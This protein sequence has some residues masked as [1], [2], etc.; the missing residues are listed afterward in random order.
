MDDRKRPA[1]PLNVLLAAR[2]VNRLGAFTL[3]FLAVLLTTELDASVGTAGLVLTVF[4]LATIPSRL[5]G[6][7][8]SDRIGPRRTIVLGLIGCAAGQLWLAVAHSIGSAFAA[9]CLLGLAFEIYE[10]PSQALVAELV[11]PEE[12][13]RAYGRFGAALAVA[14][15]GAGLLAALLAG[16]DLR[17]L[18]VADAVTCLLCTLLI[19]LRL[20]VGHRVPR[21]RGGGWQDR[22]L[23]VMLAA[24]IVFATVYL[25]LMTALPLTVQA[26]GLPLSGVGLVLATSAVTMIV[27]QR[28]IRIGDDFR[29]MT[30]GYVVL[31]AGL[32]VT[33][34]ARSLPMLLAATVVWSIG[35][36]ILLG[37]TQ[38]IVAGLAPAGARGRYLATYGTCWGVAAAVGPLAGTQLLA[39]TGPATL[40]FTCA[41]IVAA[42]AITQPLVKRVV[43]AGPDRRTAPG[44]GT[45][46]ARAPRGPGRTPDRRRR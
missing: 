18:F 17:W 19:A 20:P 38:S 44:A 35:D 39:R 36:L 25:Q 42:L 14:A 40:W 29:A 37:R 2:V 23:M 43:G 6:G 10:P 28:L 32:L 46:P 33:G 4:G 11:P 5:A 31:A 21:S 8:L 34:L 1:G 13:S 16:L 41:A 22:R 27:A 7:R 30:I 15:V 24:G 26:R 3:P 45:A 9:A 12:R